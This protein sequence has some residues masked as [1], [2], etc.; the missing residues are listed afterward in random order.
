MTK[1]IH[2]LTLRMAVAMV[3]L[4]LVACTG[5]TFRIEGN[6]SQAADS[7]LYLEHMSLTGPVAVDSTSLDDNGSFHFTGERPQT[8]EFY[9]LRIAN[10]IINISIDSTETVK[11]PA[12]SPTMASDYTVAGSDNCVKIRQLALMQQQLMAR[13]DAVQR[14]PTMGV[15]LTNDSVMAMVERYKYNVAMDY[16]YH[17]PHKAYAYF[18]LFQTIGGQLIFNPRETESDIRCFA[19]VATS[20][21]TYYPGSERGENLHNIAI[22]GMKTLRIK[23]AR[24]NSPVIDTDKIEVTTVIDVPLTDN[25]G[26]QRSITELRGKVVMLDFHVFATDDS[27]ERIMMLRDLYNK[28]H[29][30]GLEI[31]QVSLDSDEHFWKTQTAALPWI[32]VRDDDALQS[33]YLM[34]YN[35]SELP[36][37]FLIDR[38]NAL[39]KRDTQIKNIDDELT[40]LLK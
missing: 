11:V 3:A 7:M 4:M 29:D 27:R 20:W 19:A 2:T 36:T 13:I 33:Q 14:D 28:Y 31:Y 21:D 10:S 25:H 17:E 23:Y 38:N 18:A 24:E 9:R 32:S 39:Y 15:Q 22:E 26:R 34:R 16:I 6:I 37:F 12:A 30:Q 5:E 8:P 35:V 1:T 40:T